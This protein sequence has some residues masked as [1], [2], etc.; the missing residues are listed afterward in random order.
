MQVRWTL[1]ELLGYVG[2]WSA[3]LRFREN[4]GY[5][6]VAGFAEELAPGWG[7]PAAAQ[8]IHWPLSVR[9]GRKPS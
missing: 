3:T 7:D 2:T 8:L 1:A 5:D 6:P 4:R 9:V